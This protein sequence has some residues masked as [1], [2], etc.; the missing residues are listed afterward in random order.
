MSELKQTKGFAQFRGIIGGLERV[1][2]AI[3]KRSETRQYMDSDKIKK[4]QFS[5]KTS[6]DNVLYVEVKQFKTGNS[7]KNVYI[8][9]RDEESKKTETKAVPFNERHRSFEDG[10]KIIGIALKSHNDE[11]AKSLVPYDAIDYIL[12]NFQDGDSVFLNTEMSHSDDGKG[13][14]YTNYEIK[15]MYVTKEPIDFEAENFEEQA[16]FVEDIVFSDVVDTGENAF[17]KAFAINYRG[18]PQECQFMI[19]AV[20]KEV[21]EFFKSEV[22]FGDV[23]SVEGLVNNRVVYS[24]RD[25]SEEEQDD[26]PMVGRKTKSSQNNSKIREIESENRSLQIIGVADVKKGLYT[27]EELGEGDSESDLPF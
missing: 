27:A 4:L 18:E 24:Y 14:F 11:Y 23:V 21:I 17:V 25:A 3:T 9:K 6:D 2:E 15:R 20:D 5:I 13:K 7:L 26:K 1:K 19:E 10:W 8:S 16:D 12:E 22:S